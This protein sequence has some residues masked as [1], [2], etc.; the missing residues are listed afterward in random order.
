MND[1]EHVANNYNLDE[2]KRA[3]RYDPETGT[4]TK[5]DYIKDRC[6]KIGFI[7]SKGYITIK[8][9]GV[10]IKAHRIAWALHYGEWPEQELDHINRD[11]RDNRIVNLRLADRFINNQN[12]V[13]KPKLSL[14]TYRARQLMYLD[15]IIQGESPK[16]IPHLC[17][18]FPY[19][20]KNPSLQ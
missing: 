17:Y 4:I 14:E 5:Y 12:R 18:Y 13:F 10:A 7:D 20:F 9:D 19:S 2:I 15:M 11:E 1:T 3:Y 8:H 16:N 6:N